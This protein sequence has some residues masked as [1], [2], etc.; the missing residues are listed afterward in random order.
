MRAMGSKTSKRSPG[1]ARQEGTGRHRKVQEGTR[2]Y[3]KVQRQNGY[4]L[5]HPFGSKVEKVS[6]SYR[7]PPRVTFTGGTVL[8]FASRFIMPR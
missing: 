6:P 3:K 8:G 7:S 5:L 4:T 1:R 2:R